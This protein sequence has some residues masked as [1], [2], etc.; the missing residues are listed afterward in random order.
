[1]AAANELAGCSSISPVLRRLLY[2]SS[3]TQSV[4]ALTWL[5]TTMLSMTILGLVVLSLRA[6]FYNPVIRGR[7][8]KRREKEFEDYKL[9]MS[10]FYDTSTWELNWVPETSEEKRDEKSCW[11]TDSTSGDITP[12]ASEEQED[13]NSSPGLVPAIV[14]SQD[15][16]VF[17]NLA[18]PVREGVGTSE[19]VVDDEDSDYDSTY[20]YDSVDELRSTMSSSSSVFSMIFQRRRQANL[21]RLQPSDLPQVNSSSSWMSRF[22]TRR[23]PQSMTSSGQRSSR[24]HQTPQSMPSSMSSDFQTSS[25]PEKKYAKQ[26]RASYLDDAFYH[27]SDDDHEDDS[28]D[29]DSLAGVFLTPPSVQQ[30]MRLR[31]VD[32]KQNQSRNVRVRDDP[33]GFELEPL[34]P[35]YRSRQV[36]NPIAKIFE[37]S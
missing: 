24:S 21:E 19:E 26:T 27:D 14:A 36:K 25:S 35:N 6:A 37:I 33:E 20:S 15:G 34:T 32:T 29:I 7:R 1:M 23:T 2:G 31:P 16:S 4:K 17:L 3:C 13:G 8:G 9:Y 22:M 12:T 5:W 11:E 18:I 10:K 30:R 28:I